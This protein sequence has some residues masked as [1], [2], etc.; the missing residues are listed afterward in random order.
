MSFLLTGERLRKLVAN[1]KWKCRI[2]S[3]LNFTE[4]TVDAI[5]FVSEKF[6]T[7]GFTDYVQL[8]HPRYSVA[9]DV[10][11]DAGEEPAQ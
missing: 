4:A 2:S 3:E 10:E 1:V 6:E 11:D 9:T 8:R 5:E 7:P